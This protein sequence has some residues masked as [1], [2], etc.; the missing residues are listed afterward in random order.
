[1]SDGREMTLEEIAEMYG[2]SHR[3][4]REYR[5]LAHGIRMLDHCRWWEMFRKNKIKRMLIEIIADIDKMRK[6]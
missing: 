6:V 4:A 2:S 5:R 3:A 1:M